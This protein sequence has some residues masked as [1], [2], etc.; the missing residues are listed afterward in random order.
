MNDELEQLESQATCAGKTIQSDQML[1]R[2]FP[3]TQGLPHSNHRE[4]L[5]PRQWHLESLHLRVSV[6]TVQRFARQRGSKLQVCKAQTRSRFFAGSQQQTANASSGIFRVY[7]ERPDSGW[8]PLWIKPGIVLCRRMHV[9]ATVERAPT[10]PSAAGHELRSR[11]HNEVRAIAHKLSVHPQ[12]ASQRRFHLLGTVTLAQISR[13][14]RNQDLEPRYIVERC[15]AN[16]KLRM[17]L[18]REYH[19][20]QRRRVRVAKPARR[21]DIKNPA[22]VGQVATPL[23]LQS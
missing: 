2:N 5:A 22:D 7:E 1:F 3:R 15:G 21:E 4:T 19:F 20:T 11:F 13:R 18:R 12:S 9:I 8:F 17:H 6:S 14:Q 10:T 23:N 16:V